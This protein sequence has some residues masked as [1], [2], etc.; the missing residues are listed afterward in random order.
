M[1]RGKDIKHEASNQLKTRVVAF[2]WGVFSEEP[3][4]PPNSYQIQ[5]LTRSSHE[6]K[7][8]PPANP[9]P[10]HSFTMRVAHDNVSR[11]PEIPHRRSPRLPRRRRSPYLPT[12][13][14]RKGRDR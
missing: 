10:S 9:P 6:P 3:I 4:F 1:V 5:P 14:P 2:R 11:L 12:G 7:P 13:S 8:N